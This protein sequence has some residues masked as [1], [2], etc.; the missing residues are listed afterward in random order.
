[1]E[2]S[3]L[4]KYVL[5]DDG[6]IETSH[7]GEV[8][9]GDHLRPFAKDGK[10]R[11]VLTGSV[12]VGFNVVERTREVIETSD[13]YSALERAKEEFYE[14]IPDSRFNKPRR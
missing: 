3:Q 7:S 4:K 10:G 6:S 9:D 11:L 2:L 13:S 5:F 8:Q 1:M 12:A 14:G